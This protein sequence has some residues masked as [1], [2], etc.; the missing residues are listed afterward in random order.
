MNGELE[1][2]VV[3]TFTPW[4][5]GCFFLGLIGWLGIFYFYFDGNWPV[6]GVMGN[7]S[8]GAVSAPSPVASW[9]G[10]PKAPTGKKL[11][12]KPHWFLF[13]LHMQSRFWKGTVVSGDNWVSY[14]CWTLDTLKE[15]TDT[16]NRAVLCHTQTTFPSSCSAWLGFSLISP[17]R[18]AWPGPPQPCWT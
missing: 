5:R 16:S 12:L 4:L 7:C 14:C 2:L 15:G 6:E 3:K 8:S 1:A 18:N 9:D 13:R 17:G 11:G 10:S